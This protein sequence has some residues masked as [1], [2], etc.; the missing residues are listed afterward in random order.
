MSY[1]LDD[2]QTLKNLLG[3]RDP[4]ELSWRAAEAVALRQSQI[5]EGLGPAM[6]LDLT[7]F[8][9]PTTICSK[10]FPNG[11]LIFATKSSNC[12][13]AREP[14]VRAE[15]AARVFSEGS[16]IPLELNA[17]MTR[18][19]DNQFLH[20]RTCSGFAIDFDAIPAE[21]MTAAIAASERG[22]MALLRRLFDDAVRAVSEIPEISYIYLQQKSDPAHIFPNSAV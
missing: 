18:L 16:Q 3:A 7:C 21:R 9:N 19:R 1:T 20:R 10:T 13:M 17:L 12:R 11:P 8:K 4:G 14:V 6:T 2:G 5:S 15:S 22:E